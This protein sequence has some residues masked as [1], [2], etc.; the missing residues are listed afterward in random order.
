MTTTLVNLL[1]VNLR[2]RWR[3][4][5]TPDADGALLEQMRALWGADVIRPCRNQTLRLVRSN[6]NPGQGTVTRVA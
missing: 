5:W 3:A 1:W 4:W 2:V 6:P